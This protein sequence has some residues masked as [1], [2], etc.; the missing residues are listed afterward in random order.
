MPLIALIYLVAGVG[1]GFGEGFRLRN[2]FPPLGFPA[3]LGIVLILMAGRGGIMDT[4]IF[5]ASTLISDEMPVISAYIIYG[6]SW[7]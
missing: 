7:W 3:L 5:R 1:A 6:W 2:C 4:I